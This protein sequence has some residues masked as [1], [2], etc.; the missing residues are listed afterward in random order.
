MK[1]FLV[2]SG[3]CFILGA[4]AL[5]KEPTPPAEPAA[6]PY[7]A[8]TETVGGM[9]RVVMMPLRTEIRGRA[10]RSRIETS[11]QRAISERHLF[12]MIPVSE[13]DIADTD[14]DST[15]K[16]GTFTTTDLITLSRRF[17]ADGVLH[18]VVTHFQAY[19]QVVLGLRLTLLDCRTGRVP[20]ATEVLLDASTRT[21]K[22][23]VHNFYDTQK[24]EEDSL[25]D[26]EK[27]LVSPR[28]FGEYASARIAGT[29]ANALG[30]RQTT[31]S[32]GRKP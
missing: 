5:I 25:L 11:L 26:H 6:F 23:D 30:H 20:W 2:V 13:S 12:E 1:S 24:W 17:G 29:M 27:V 16:K 22:Q 4:C 15:R 7:H 9:R 19:P 31:A 14:F 8:E 3:A 10:V 21:V 32:K 18:G 28:L